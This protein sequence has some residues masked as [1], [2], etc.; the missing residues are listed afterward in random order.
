MTNWNN[1]L[2]FRYYPNDIIQTTLS[3]QQRRLDEEF[4]EGFLVEFQTIPWITA[5]REAT[6][7][8]IVGRENTLLGER[9]ILDKFPEQGG[10]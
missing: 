9:G 1:L 2:T 5:D 4:R 8:A 6:F 10:T 3:Q 7:L